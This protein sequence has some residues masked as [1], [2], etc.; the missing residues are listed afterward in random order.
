MKVINL[1]AVLYLFIL[2]INQAQQL[3]EE[4]I[5]QIDQLFASFDSK[6]SPGYAIGIYKEGQALYEKGYGMANLDY[7]IPITAQSVFNVASVSKQFTAACIA[8][9]ILDGKLNLDDNAA[10]FIP[11]LKK[12]PYEIKIN[13]LI[14]MCSGLKEYYTLP[15]ATGLDWNPA[16]YFTIDTA[17]AVVLN[18]PDLDYRP[19]SKRSYSNINY[20]LLARIVEKISGMGFDEFAQKRI[21]EP[22]KMKNTH[23][24]VDETRVVKNRVIGYNYRNSEQGKEAGFHHHIRNSPHYGGSGLHTTSAD[25]AKWN[26]NFFNKEKLGGQAFYDLMHQTMKFEFERNNEGFGLGI[27]QYKGLDLIQYDGGDQGF[28]SYVGRFPEEGLTFVCLSNLGTG[29]CWRFGH[30]LID[31]VLEENFIYPTP[32][33]DGNASF[34]L[35]GFQEARSVFLVGQFNNWNSWDILMK[36]VEGGW[37]CKIDLPAGN[38]HYQFVVDN[39]W[40][41]DPNNPERAKSNE[42]VLNSIK[43][44][45]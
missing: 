3:S 39:Q 6:D 30:Q 7:D 9:L 41:L 43:N 13:H 44:I 27:N 35:K 8:L 4:K 22:L 40:I 26:A 42:G 45:E 25:L 32:K 1:I 5:N 17:I 28:S 12:Y 29:N 10:D 21:F 20:M 24:N 15:R 37:L 2:N 34:F 16:H 18:E 33:L 31:I 14:Y 36:K 11:E 19:G 23:F 38:H